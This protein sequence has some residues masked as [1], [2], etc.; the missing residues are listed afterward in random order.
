M[1]LG[2][3]DA[4]AGDA[5]S[6][7]DTPRWLTHELC[8]AR[9]RRPS[10][11]SWPLAHPARPLRV[12][13]ATSDAGPTRRCCTGSSRSTGRPSSSEPSSPAACLT[14]S[15]RSSRRTYAA[16]CSSTA[17]PTSL[18]GSVANRWPWRTHARRGQLQLASSSS[19][20]PLDR[21]DSDQAVM[22]EPCLELTEP[23]RFGGGI[24][25]NGGSSCHPASADAPRRPT[26]SQGPRSIL[27][28]HRS[29]CGG[30]GRC[31]PKLLRGR[32][33]QLVTVHPGVSVHVRSLGRTPQGCNFQTM[34]ALNGVD[35][36]RVVYIDQDLR[37][38]SFAAEMSFLDWYERWADRV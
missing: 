19:T 27:V 22:V 37:K 18:V 13:T 38:P 16:A 34:L 6:I 9:A 35:T 2:R 10:S 7:P 12:E 15:S 23:V 36:G 11:R 1:G 26:T 4:S 17:S 25:P 14:S 24:A 30:G 8:K 3:P 33:F 5:A 20:S 21:P 29:S 31:P 32:T 28:G